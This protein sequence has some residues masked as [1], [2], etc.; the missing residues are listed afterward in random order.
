MPGEGSNPA[1]YFN[2]VSDVVVACPFIGGQTVRFRYK[3]LGQHIRKFRFDSWLTIS[4]T[5]D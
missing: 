4:N 1:V 2:M 5:G 3:C